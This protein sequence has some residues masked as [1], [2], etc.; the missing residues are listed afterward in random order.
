MILLLQNPTTDQ[1]PYALAPIRFPTA[2]LTVP[3]PPYALAPLRFDATA[4]AP[5]NKLDAR[6]A[7]RPLFIVRDP[8]NTLILSTPSVCTRPEDITGSPDLPPP[9]PPTPAPPACVPSATQDT[10]HITI[11]SH[12][13]QFGRGPFTSPCDL[14]TPLWTGGDPWNGEL[15]RV[16]PGECFW[17]QPPGLGDL[18]WIDAGPVTVVGGVDLF[19]THDGNDFGLSQDNAWILRFNAIDGTD[20]GGDS[21]WYKLTD[22]DPAGSYTA[23]CPNT[24][25]NSL[26]IS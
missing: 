24:I 4:P 23:L 16:S 5:S 14:D 8:P 9:D 2:P 11:T 15:E 10:Y 13:T 17:Q 26:F 25:P 6:N 20:G 3:S 18:S 21:L 12:L 19:L 7:L 1:P 22:L